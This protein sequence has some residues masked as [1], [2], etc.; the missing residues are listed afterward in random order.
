MLTG[1]LFGVSLRTVGLYLAGQRKLS[2]FTYTTIIMFCLFSVLAQAPGGVES[3]IT[4]G[5]RGVR[6]LMGRPVG[7]CF[8]PGRGRCGWGDG[9]APVRCP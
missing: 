8:T 6:M 1:W 2:G 9:A 5:C 3:R 7:L 4:G